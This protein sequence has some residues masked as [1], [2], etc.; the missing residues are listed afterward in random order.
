MLTRARRGRGER[1]V[2]GLARIHRACREARALRRIEGADPR[3]EIGG[4]TEI[5][6]GRSDG[7]APLFDAIKGFPRGFRIFTNATTSPQRAALAL[8][9]DATLRPLDTLKA[10]MDKRANRHRT[11]RLELGARS[12]HSRGRQVARHH[13]AFE[14]DHRSLPAVRLDWTISP[15]SALS[16]AEARA[17]E[18]KW[19]A[20]LK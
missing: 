8:G 13:R 17:I 19:G 10:W 18:E 5:A 4:I 7:P 9:I 6:A 2:Q 11:Q 16:L 14:A 15:T 3:F 20:A 12:A 1:H